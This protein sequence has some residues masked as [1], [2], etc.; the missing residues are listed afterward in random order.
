VTDIEEKIKVLRVYI[1]ATKNEG[2]EQTMLWAEDEFVGSFAR[3]VILKQLKESNVGY[4]FIE[5]GFMIFKR[6]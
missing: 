4:R 6:T 1:D 5:D 2:V 3:K